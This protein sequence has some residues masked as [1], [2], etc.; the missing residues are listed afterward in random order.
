VLQ[1][2]I[3][4]FDRDAASNQV[5]PLDNRDLRKTLAVP[6]FLE[7]KFSAALH[8]YP[9]VETIPLQNFAPLM[10]DRDYCLEAHFTWQPGVEGVI[11]SIGDNMGGVCVFVQAEHVVA[12]FVG[13]RGAER[14]CRLRL[15][16]GEQQLRL[17]HRALGQREGLGQLVLN[18]VMAA[19]T[20]V[21][22]P[23]FLRLVGEGIDVGLDRRRKVSADCEGR[24]VYRYGAH[25]NRVSLTP[26][27]QAPGSLANVPEAI[28]Q[29]D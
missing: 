2:L 8:F 18:G 26:G 27:P 20:L 15:T 7:K 10:S 17:E 9:G 4:E 14:Q 28:A 29:W 24:G 19:E 5:Y 16:P 12:A 21:M 3:A 23:T 22:T 13:T 6:P 25:I 1:Q 11:F